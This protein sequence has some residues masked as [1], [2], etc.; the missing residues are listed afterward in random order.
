MSRC[1][2][3]DVR[4]WSTVLRGLD[5]EA[6]PNAPGALKLPQVACEAFLRAPIKWRVD[7][8]SNVSPSPAH[9]SLKVELY[10]AGGAVLPSGTTDNEL[11]AH[12]LSVQVDYWKVQPSELL[13]V[14]IAPVSW[15]AWAR[16]MVNGKCV[17]G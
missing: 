17:C 7:A 15:P 13:Y 1:T 11:S 2:C 5:P 10:C 12:G 6:S 4:S 9:A 14:C 8:Y 3:V 16:P